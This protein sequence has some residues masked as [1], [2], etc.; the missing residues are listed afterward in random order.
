MIFCDGVNKPTE[1]KAI[2]GIAKP[3]GNV[4]AQR[5]A[6]TRQVFKANK[7][8]D[9]ALPVNGIRPIDLSILCDFMRFLQLWA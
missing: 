1:L 3:G 2:V 9:V 4:L 8:I 5:Y 6:P 7:S